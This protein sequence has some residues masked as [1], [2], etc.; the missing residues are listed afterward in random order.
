M[1]VP[2]RAG[3]RRLRFAHLRK[4]PWVAFATLSLPTTASGMVRCLK[5][6]SLRSA[7][8]QS[9]QTYACGNFSVYRPLRGKA[10]HCHHP[11]D[12][13]APLSSLNLW[14]ISRASSKRYSARVLSIFVRPGLAVPHWHGVLKSPSLDGRERRDYPKSPRRSYPP[15]NRRAPAF[16]STSQHPCHGPI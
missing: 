9:R 5:V 14:Q 11:L 4:P 6:H 1:S 15:Q 3:V 2:G 10:R 8:R 7:L 13:R 16:F 12:R